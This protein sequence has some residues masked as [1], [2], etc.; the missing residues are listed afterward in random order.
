MA[1]HKQSNPFQFSARRTPAVIA[2]LV[3]ILLFTVPAYSQVF[4]PKK[5]MI[6]TQV[7]AS[8]GFDSIIALTNRGSHDYRGDIYFLTGA[9]GIVWNPLVN[10]VRLTGGWLQVLIP[11][12]ETIVLRI[13]DTAFVV[14]YAFIYADDLEA[15]N[16]VEGN[17]TYYS[18][19]IGTVLDAVGVPE[20]REFLVSSLPFSEFS[21]VGLSLAVPKRGPNENATVEVLLYDED[22]TLVSQC[23]FPVLFGG[24]FAK[25]LGELPW[26]SSISGM[27][28]AGKV[29]IRSNRLIA[30][31]GMTVTPGA[32]GAAEISTLPLSGTPL[33][34]TLEAEDSEENV[35]V[36]DV[37]FWIEG[38][39]VNGFMRL[40][41]INGEEIENTQ[42]WKV[43]GQLIFD[44]MKLAFP[45]ILGD[46]EVVPEVSL[47]ILM[48]DFDPSSAELS[49]TWS[50]DLLVG[51]ST[52]ERGTVTI[53]KVVN[54]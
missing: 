5:D 4:Y 24:H 11:T 32:G 25:F 34:Y 39:V 52:P 7:I 1:K 23:Q 17:L 45:C 42:T 26:T 43:T 36:G 51:S 20:S 16:A 38:Y 31:I 48:P 53:T 40:S 54:P 46:T 35:Y 10:G 49:G 6:F 18:H 19:D 21:N 9:A 33:F 27:G 13:T 50:A 15:D 2:G 28:P 44:E 8:S 41:H 3:L 14:G 30:G 29:E 37:T 47:F 22:S 12:N